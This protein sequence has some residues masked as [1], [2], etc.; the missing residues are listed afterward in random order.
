MF[1]IFSQIPLG[2]L[3]KC[4]LKAL[5]EGVDVGLFDLVAHVRT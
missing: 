5:F 2:G 3:L 4:L 1:H